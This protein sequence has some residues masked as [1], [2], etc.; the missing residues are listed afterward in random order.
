MEY[1]FFW[2]EKKTG[3]F[4][5]NFYPSTF[6]IN[7]D[8]FNCSEQYF[9]KKKQELF[10][11]KNNVLGTQIMNE[12]NP[13]DIKKY[14]RQVKNFTEDKWNMHKYK[15]MYDGVYAK[16]SQ[17]PQLKVKL[18]ET[19]DKILV[20]ASPFDRI[21]GIGFSETNAIVNKSKWGENLLGKILMEIREKLK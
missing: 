4:L 21:W 9:M 13:K 7:T 17:N 3:G 12:T 11:P 15:F 8:T 19:G 10:D 18:L 1:L 5:S 2:G 6:T 16:F 14:G 20:E